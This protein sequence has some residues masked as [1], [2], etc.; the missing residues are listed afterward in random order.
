MFK[1]GDHVWAQFGE[2]PQVIAHV[3]GPQVDGKYPVQKPDGTIVPLTHR[4]PSDRDNHGAGG[5][6]WAV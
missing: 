1:T 3:A 2:E 5:T 6:F 4:E